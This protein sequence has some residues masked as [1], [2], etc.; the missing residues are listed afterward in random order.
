MN[1]AE[2]DVLLHALIDGELDAGHTRDV[3]AHVATCPGCA[4]KLDA[5]RAMREAMAAADLKERAPAHLRSSIEAVPVR[6]S[7]RS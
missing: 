7:W 4:E 1:C 5:F 3:E 6:P 2:C